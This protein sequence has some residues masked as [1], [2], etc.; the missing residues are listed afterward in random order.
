MYSRIKPILYSGTSY[1]THPKEIKRT[2]LVNTICLIGLLFGVTFIVIDFIQGWY[3]PL[4]GL[5]VGNVFNGLVF[6]LNTRANNHAKFAARVLLIVCSY[7][8]FFAN[9]NFLFVG[10]MSEFF[11]FLIMIMTMVLIDSFIIQGVTL[12]ICLISFY[13]P[14]MLFEW[15]DPE[16][17]GYANMGVLFITTFWII[18]QLINLNEEQQ[19]QLTRDNNIIL[20]Q[21]NEIETYNE[22]KSQFFIN[23]SHE[24]RTPL[25][26]LQG[27]TEYLSASSDSL[28]NNQQQTITTIKEQGE[29][30]GQMLTNLL[31]VS[32][33]ASPTLTLNKESISINLFADRLA[34]RF[35]PVFEQKEIAFWHQ[36]PQEMF[37]ID[38]DRQLLESAVSNLL[39]N[40][41]KFT[42]KAGTVCLSVSREGQHL[43]ISV[44]DNGPGI[45]EHEIPFVFDRF[46]R[47]TN[48]ISAEPGT[49]I[50]LSFTKNIADEHGFELKVSSNPF[51]RTEFMLMIPSSSFRLETEELLSDH[52]D[53]VIPDAESERNIK[54]VLIVEDNAQMRTY[55]ADMLRQ[56]HVETASNGQAALSI[57]A[58]KS[59]DVVITD[60][61]MPGMT[62]HELVGKIKHLKPDL[63]IIVLTARADSPAK[64]AMLRLGIDAYITKPFVKEELLHTL[65]R[66]LR[67]QLKASEEQDSLPKAQKSFME[68]HAQQ[69]NE[70][71][72]TFIS[73]HLK[74][75]NFS[76]ERI[77]EH[78][79]ISKSTLNR[80]VKSLLG[81]TTKEI[82]KEARL[83]QAR[84]LLIQK[85]NAT[86]KEVAR[87]VGIANSTYLF[88]QLE[89]RFGIKK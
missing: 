88:E 33:L 53:P 36:L 27:Y 84:D 49:G 57:L 35:T 81:Q 41:L 64:R 5:V 71:L 6:F 20:R 72:N 28:T 70:E 74:S 73:T 87:Q 59:F 31:T 11:Y 50:G 4:L 67:Y 62:G 56:F 42:S 65:Q 51:E 69:F 37:T 3:E 34:T 63:P 48:V 40:A 18:R 54:K 16:V 43:V 10:K 14:N 21:K 8:F 29:H 86:Q 12:T 58:K 77:A 13:L 75:H 46:F 9:A 85:P 80:R 44:S 17:F 82:I 68:E 25:T 52:T 47:A 55:V 30:I 38:A 78:F 32:T 45:P 22:I 39:T 7:A 66:S 61:M 2:V 1:L 83:Q 23:L 19:A 15:Y 89:E 60:Y 26:L 24:I 76:V 79:D